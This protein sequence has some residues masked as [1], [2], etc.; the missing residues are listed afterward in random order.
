M[1]PR[2]LLALVAVG[3]VALGGGWYFGVAT[4]PSDQQPVNAGKLAFPDLTA[5][6]PQTAKIEIVHQGKPLVIERHG[7]AWGLTDRSLYPV[8]ETK[9]RGMLTGLTE[10]RLVEPRT[11]DPA[12]YAVL[13]VEDPTAKDV[14]GTSDLLR[15][16][17][18]KGKPIA[19]LI[20]GHRRMRTQGNV[21]D[22]VY[23]RRPGAKQSWLAEG[24]LQVEADPQL[25]LDRDIMN[26]DHAQIARVVS[27]RGDSQVE[28]D[29]EG[30]KLVLKSPEQ[31]PKLDPY[32]LQDV[33]RALELLTFEDVH[34]TDDKAGSPVGHSVFTTTDGMTITITVFQPPA[35]QSA[36]PEGDRHVLVRF[37]VASQDTGQGT[38]QDAGQDRSKAQ[39]EELEHKLAGWTYQLGAWKEH[40]LLP[41][42]DTLKAPPPDASNAAGTA[43]SAKP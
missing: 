2:T 35:D 1:K 3:V 32:K 23:V 27:V 38:G 41:A 22:E 4:A 34:K 18:A 11:A 17:D 5:R 40:A 30:G 10:L 6:L 26:L 14:S 20:V 36:K 43:A 19:A 8:Q 13:G 15:L 42:I 25:W 16:V 12:Q 7:D 28:L 29:R 24:S 37:A 39:A 9:L 21:P 31:H 33:S